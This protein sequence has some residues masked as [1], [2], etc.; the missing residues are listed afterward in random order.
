M[1]ST[2]SGLLFF[3][4]SLSVV[5]GSLKAVIAAAGPKALF[6]HTNQ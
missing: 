1:K 5:T 6:A 2:L 3:V 4:L